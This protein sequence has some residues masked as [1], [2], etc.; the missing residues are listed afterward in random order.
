MMTCRCRSSEQR[1]WQSLQNRRTRTQAEHPALG[2]LR[3]ALPTRCH[4]TGGGGGG[5][6]GGLG[7]RG[8]LPVA[9]F[10]VPFFFVAFF[11]V[12]FFF[13]AFFFVAFFFVPLDFFERLA[14]LRGLI[15][16]LLQ[17]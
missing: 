14:F 11:F 4:P 12:P 9:F 10:F 5:G 7:G 6:L 3:T 1:D 13:V 16:D 15:S 17:E 8:G 2:L